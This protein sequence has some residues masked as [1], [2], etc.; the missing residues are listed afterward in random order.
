M[1]KK[2]YLIQ[3]SYRDD[4]GKILKGKKLYVIS[5]A[6]PALSAIVPD[7]WEKEFCYEYFDEINFDSDASVVGIS[8]MGYEIFRGAEIADEFK[9]RGKTVIFG[10]FQPHLSTDYIKS[11]CDSVVHGNPGCND[12]AKILKDIESNT[13]KK[14]YFCKTDLNYKFDYS[15]LDSSRVFFTPVL[16]SVGCNHNCEFCCISSIYKKKYTLRKIKYLIE[17]LDELHKTT[18]NIAFV[19]TNLYNNRDYLIKLCKIMIEHKYKFVWGGQS[20]F[21]IGDD[22]EVLNLLS[23]SGCKV[24]FIGIESIDQ[25]NLNYL[26]KNYDVNLFRQKI[27]N[28][29]NAGIKIAAFF[30]YGLDYDS[31]DTS[32]HLSKFIIDNNIALPMLN[33][34]V[35]NPGSRLYN[36]LKSQGRVLIQ[37]ELDFLKNNIAYNSSFKMCYFIPKNMTTL[38]VEEGFIDLLKRLSGFYQ[39][40]KRSL[41]KSLTLSAFL[42]Y[43]NWLFRKEYIELKRKRL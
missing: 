39:L 29:H 14:E 35:P 16:S 36:Q 24:L 38:Q 7:G 20:T 37:N 27:K 4:T 2:I 13:V 17:E 15:V 5:L 12:M 19:D 41:S 8:S 21:N 23:K 11:H 34:L 3:P 43:M 9:K 10:G 26:N 1:K 32:K 31:L 18:R 25:R 33:I 22:I 30:I 40:I 42:L 28:I 6:L